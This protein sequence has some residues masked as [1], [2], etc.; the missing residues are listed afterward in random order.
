METSPGAVLV[1]DSEE[2]IRAANRKVADAPGWQFEVTESD[3]GPRFEF[4]GLRS[5]TRV[6]G[7]RLGPNRTFI[8]DTP[9]HPVMTDD[10]LSVLGKEY[11]VTILR[12]AYVPV[13]APELAER[14]DIPVATCYRRLNELHEAGLVTAHEDSTDSGRT[15]TR[16]QRRLHDVCVRF[17]GNEVTIETNEETDAS[18]MLDRVWRGLGAR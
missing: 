4:L 12:E 3:A 9:L 18:G 10:V 2:T 6:V 14:H 1:A 17:D 7:R 13:S 8:S 15:T 5:A 11:A 16:Y